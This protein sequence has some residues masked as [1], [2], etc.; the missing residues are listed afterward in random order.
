MQKHDEVKEELIKTDIEFRRLYQDHQ[1]HERRIDQ[2]LRTHDT[3]TDDEIELKALKIQK[4]RLKD[5]MEEMIRT[6]IEGGRVS[7]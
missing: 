2:M 7:A 6:R 5:R 1:D 4:L 3:S